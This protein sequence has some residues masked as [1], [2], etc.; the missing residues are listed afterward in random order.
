MWGCGVLTCA[1]PPD[2]RGSETKARY[3]FLRAS[4]LKFFDDVSIAVICPTCQT[5][6]KV[7]QSH[8]QL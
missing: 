1:P 8:S 6:M 5:L 4:F 2:W 7:Q 3:G